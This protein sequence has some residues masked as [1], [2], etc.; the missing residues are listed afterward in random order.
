MKTAC[1]QFVEYMN[2]VAQEKTT[3]LQK[4]KEKEE[5]DKK[6]LLRVAHKRHKEVL[7]RIRLHRKS[8]LEEEEKRK[9]IVFEQLKQ[10]ALAESKRKAEEKKKQLEDDKKWAEFAQKK[11]EED[12]R[13]EELVRKEMEDYYKRLTA[14]SEKR[15]KRAI[16]K[17]ERLNLKE[18]RITFF[19]NENKKMQEL[20]KN[21]EQN[22]Q[23][24]LSNVVVKEEQLWKSIRVEEDEMKN[25]VLVLED[26]ESNI[27]QE[28]VTN[29]DEFSS[30]TRQL[31]LNQSFNNLPKWTKIKLMENHE[32]KSK[33]VVTNS[34]VIIRRKDISP[35]KTNSSTK[36]K[37]PESFIESAV[38]RQD[39]ETYKNEPTFYE[40]LASALSK[41]DT[42]NG[43]VKKR[44]PKELS[45]IDGR[46]RPTSKSIEQVLYPSRFSI[47]QDDNQSPVTPSKTEFILADFSLV[48]PYAKEFEG[49]KSQHVENFTSRLFPVR[50]EIRVDPQAFTPLT[51]LMENSVLIPLRAQLTVVN[52]AVVNYLL[53]DAGL[54]NHFKALRNYLL[55]HDGEF[56]HHLSYSLFS[57]VRLL[58]FYLLKM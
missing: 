24:N 31:I 45:T 40:S 7:E 3:T 32:K 28:N 11:E 46:K 6:A 16:W 50:S 26:Q 25:L 48:Q 58:K 35:P 10:Q 13:R 56:A 42:I 52:N 55:F 27:V 43:N 37:R 29:F 20:I 47:H 57:Q 33:Q 38:K 22:Q 14:E 53:V 23:N 4:I 9:R 5:E 30:D 39:Q 41:D 1:H 17:T 21:L 18:E 36:R 19:R 44:R 15:E 2:E 51:M 12:I 34:D 8:V 49:M 54:M